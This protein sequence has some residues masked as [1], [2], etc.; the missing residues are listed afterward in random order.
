MGIRRPGKEVFV[1][2]LLKAIRIADESHVAIHNSA[3]ARLFSPAIHYCDGFGRSR[4]IVN[5]DGTLSVCVE[6]NSAGHPG[7]KYFLIDSLRGSS[8]LEQVPVGDQNVDCRECFA[9]FI[10]AGGCPSRNYHHTGDVSQPDE[11]RCFV[12]R[13]VVPE[14]ILRS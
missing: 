2:A 11:Y 13:S 14:I 1:E 12:V 8:C 3:F 10:C 5:P 7:A 9:R 6:A 4:R